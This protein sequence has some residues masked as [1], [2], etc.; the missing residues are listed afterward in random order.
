ML[1]H[2]KSG[3]ANAPHCYVY[4]YISCLVDSNS[5]KKYDSDYVKFICEYFMMNLNYTRLSL[6][7][8]S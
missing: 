8:V 2:G 7:L 1:F 3:Y 5:D 6:I 4:T